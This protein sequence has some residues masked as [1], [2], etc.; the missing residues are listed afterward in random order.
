MDNLFSNPGNRIK[1][2]AKV[3]F[4]IAIVFSAILFLGGLIQLAEM[5]DYLDEMAFPYFLGLVVVCAILLFLSYIGS[6]FLYS[7]GEMVETNT[8]ASNRLDNLE[9]FISHQNTPAADRY[10]ED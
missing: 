7:F 8:N 3:S 10:R 1:A 2:I 4:I 6:L 9:Y 5:A